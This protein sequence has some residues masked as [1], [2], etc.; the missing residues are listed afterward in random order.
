MKANLNE[1]FLR[2]LATPERGQIDIWD[3]KE[4]GL[5]LRVSAGVRTWCFNYQEIGRI[6]SDAAC[7]GAGL[8]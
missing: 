2:R 1:R 5:V 6:K 3:E 8:K 7:S 4:R